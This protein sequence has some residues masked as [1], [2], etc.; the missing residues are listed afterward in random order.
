MNQQRMAG[1]TLIELL[2]T[3]TIAGILL[4]IATPSYTNITNSS[5]IAAEI[6]GLVG[7]LQFARSEAIKEGQA[8]TVCASADSTSCSGSTNWN[9]GWIVF[10]DAD[11][12]GNFDN[13]EVA[14]RI[15]KT[16]NST[17]TFQATNSVA[18]INFNR[19]GIAAGIANGTLIKLH[20]ATA[21]SNW[22]RCVSINM[23]GQIVSQKYGDVLNA[24]T[25]T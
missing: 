13:G 18:A 14:L 1:V 15:Q 19:E 25:C 2:V 22:T 3:I 8:I 20:D 9:T 16:F 6:N 17:D 4:A 21:N 7:D 12:D 10:Y 24:V 5:R 11:G 23:V